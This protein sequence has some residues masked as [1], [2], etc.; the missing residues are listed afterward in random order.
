MIGRIILDVESAKT[1]E[2]VGGWG[3][4]GKLGIGVAAVFRE[5][6][7]SY[8]L[9]GSGDWLALRQTILNADEIC[10]YNIWGFDLPLIWEMGKKEFWQSDIAK[11]IRPKVYDLFR[12][13]CLGLG[14]TPDSPP[15]AG[16]DCDTLAM[17]TLGEGKTEDGKEAP[18]MYQR[19]EFCRLHTYCMNDVRL[20]RN[21]V[22]FAK[23]HGY[24]LGANATRVRISRGRNYHFDHHTEY[25]SLADPLWA[26][27]NPTP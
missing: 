17:E 13:V 22:T 7:E 3:N 4:V 21:L 25:A 8:R 10:G 26:D 19:G 20:E 14:R 27:Q 5:Y 23:R 12:L 18:L 6:Q 9:Y 15:P 1:V 2:Q 24:L 16:F 11:V